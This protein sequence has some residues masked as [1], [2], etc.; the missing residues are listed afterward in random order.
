M[1]SER[2]GGGGGGGGGVS[3]ARAG[4]YSNISQILIETGLKLV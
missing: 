4:N 3:L 1:Y 2:G